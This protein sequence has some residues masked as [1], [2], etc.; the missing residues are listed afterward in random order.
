[1]AKYFNEKAWQ[2]AT[3]HPDWYLRLTGEGSKVI[4]GDRKAQATVPI[5][6]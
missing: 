2:E 6:P 3:R 4:R 5:Q 1:M